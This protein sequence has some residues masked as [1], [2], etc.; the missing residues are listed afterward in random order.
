MRVLGIDIGLR[1][2]GLAVSDA[3]GIAIRILPNLY[4][5]DQKE[6]IEG[7]LS[8]VNELNV[9]VVVIGRPERKTTGSRAIASRAEA[10]KKKLEELFKTLE[11]DVKIYLWDE[12]MTSKR[13]MASLLAANVPQKKR[14]ML[15]DGASA[16]VLV[17][18]FLSSGV[19]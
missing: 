9:E 18:D 16:A 2:T 8:L 11:R 19:G 15:L 6:A 3:T 5:R 1:R 13:A 10:L 12:A 7:I 17:E 14:G 4:A